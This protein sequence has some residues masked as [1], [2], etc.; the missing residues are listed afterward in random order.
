MPRVSVV[1]PTYNRPGYL[2]GAIDSALGQDFEDLE[3]VVVDDGSEEDYAR[4]TCRAFPDSVRCVEHDENRGLSAA[5]NT[6][7]EAASGEYIAFLDDDD[8]W[9]PEKIS[10]QV[11]ALKRADAAAIATCLLASVDPDGNV[12]RC[13]GSRPDGDLSETALVRNPIGTPSRVVVR[14]DALEAVGGFDESLPTKQDWDLYIRLCQ[15]HEVVCVEDHLCYR[16]VHESMSSDP[17]AA[18]RDNGRVIEK[19]RDRIEK[20]GLT[21]ATMAYYHF[22]VGRTYLEHGDRANARDH[23]SRSLSRQFDLRTSLTYLLTFVPLSGFDATLA[24]KRRLETRL[25]CRDVGAE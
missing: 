6:G 24:I 9:H 20:Q 1:I 10:R 23:L 21:A 14:A 18:A 2:D 25:Y 17:G 4:N 22:K 19:H 3:V 11:R 12:V 8:R 15:D 16:T 7:I 5:R 13:E